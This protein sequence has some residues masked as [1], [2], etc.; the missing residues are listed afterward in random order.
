MFKKHGW[1]VIGIFVMI[2]GI[3]ALTAILQQYTVNKTD[4][5][6]AAA[7]TTVQNTIT[8]NAVITP[9]QIYGQ[10]CAGQN[11]G[12]PVVTVYLP[13]SAGSL[14][15]PTTLVQVKST[16]GTASCVRS[17]PFQFTIPVAADPAMVKALL[18]GN[19]HV[20]QVIANGAVGSAFLN[21]K[22]GQTINF[23]VNLAAPK[24]T[25]VNKINS[26]K[27]S[28]TP[29]TTVSRY[30]KTYNV[31]LGGRLI[32]STT[33]LTYTD[34]SA[35][36]P[37]T[38]NTYTV[39]PAF[40]SSVPLNTI[41]T[42]LCQPASCRSSI[43]ISVPKAFTPG[44]PSLPS[45]PIG[46]VDI[47]NSTQISGW[48]CDPADY[49]KS[50]TVHIYDGNPYGVAATSA[51]R[52]AVV[53]ADL[54]R[55]DLVTAIPKVCASTPL[56]GFTLN[57]QGNPTVMALIGDGRPH[58]IYAFGVNIA[59][60]NNTELIGD[61]KSVT[62]TPATNP[63]STP[64]TSKLN[65]DG[66]YTMTWSAV[67]GAVKYAV[68]V[69]GY[70]ITTTSGTSYT[71]DAGVMMPDSSF[72]YTFVPIFNSST[73]PPSQIDPTTN[74]PISEATSKGIL[75]AVIDSVYNVVRNTILAA[76]I[77]TPPTTQTVSPG[78]T[79]VTPPPTPLP[80][81]GNLS[82]LAIVV[83]MEPNTN[84]AGAI[85]FGDDV[86]NVQKKLFTNSDST[87]Q[88]YKE[89]SYGNL[90]I[91]PVA[92]SSTSGG[93]G[94]VAVKIPFMKGFT[95]FPNDI[96]PTYPNLSLGYKIAFYLANA[97][98]K[99]FG[100]KLSNYDL[101]IYVWPI[102]P[103]WNIGVAMDG[104]GDP[105]S[106]VIKGSRIWI[107]TNQDS[108]VYSHEIG[109]VL[110]LYH[111]TGL[112]SNI[113]CMVAMNTCN[114]T[115]YG[116][117]NN[118]MGN[119]SSK[120]QMDI[121][122]KM[123]LNWNPGDQNISQS[124]RYT[125]IGRE[126]AEAKATHLQIEDT[127]DEF[128]ID[129]VTDYGTFGGNS[130]GVNFFLIRPNTDGNLGPSGTTLSMN[131]LQA[132]MYDGTS[133]DTYL[134][135]PD[136]KFAHNFHIIQI[137][138]GAKSADVYVRFDVAPT[139]TATTETTAP[140]EGKID[141]SWTAISPAPT[142]G[143]EIFRDGTSITT[144]SAT[145]TTYV[146]TGLTPGSSHTYKIRGFDSFTELPGKTYPMMFSNTANA[147][148]GASLTL[149]TPNVYA[150]IS[151]TC[152]G[153]VDVSWGAITNAV[154]YEVYRDNETT[155]F[156]TITGTSIT[157]SGFVP[158]SS[159]TIKVRA[160]NGTVYSA[161]GSATATA[162]AACSVN[163]NTPVLS[164]SVGSTCTTTVLTWTNVGANSYV[165]YDGVTNQQIGNSQAATTVT[166]T[167]VVGQTSTYYVVAYIGTSASA[168]SNTV[169]FTPSCSTPPPAL[170]DCVTPQVN[171]ASGHGMTWFGGGF[172]AIQPGNY[173][174]V[175][176]N[177]GMMFNPTGGWQI[178]HQETNGVVSM[179]MINDRAVN[180]LPGPGSY[181]SF[182]SQ[183]ALEASMG[184]ATTPVFS[185][186]YGPIGMYLWDT[187][188][189]ADNVNGNPNPTF[190][191]VKMP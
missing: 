76:V 33:N 31:Y 187:N 47:L 173:M 98:A 6:T 105:T 148:A 161:F 124:G 170:T 29:A 74:Q 41:D 113:N 3:I 147:T 4:N 164:V 182:P 8:G 42:K 37:G 78:L 43:S 133:Y 27:L 81:S 24:L 34:L 123:V 56:H 45:K 18:D 174:V 154:S 120:K 157:L 16:K 59:N 159:H 150:F 23:G 130:V 77:S 165:L 69:E 58:S 82:V 160:K 13:S 178:R 143:Y 11:V 110:G 79:I 128:F 108:D 139:L 155:P 162:S 66:S 90:K 38:I 119:S 112:D 126:Y 129:Y 35:F 144:V 115:P 171:D 75:A 48:T 9:I 125:V 26:I 86:L 71:E 7:L 145:T 175:Y 14:K 134:A 149:D 61:G 40:D 67:P 63:N 32:T 158:S 44:S 103:V 92:T 70:L 12:L 188:G 21:T 146:D 191:L 163:V 5:I 96:A 109:H 88:F 53:N 107:N 57:L 19:S 54:S 185:H 111:G 50:T 65:A 156:T 152:E 85:A 95:H 180:Y 136:G 168:H 140:V 118:I 137:K 52:I 121:Y 51:K 167:T 127:G 179:Y 135:P 22:S 104:I 94:A 138:H 122:D 116:D 73:V 10:G 46:Y 25:T 2:V 100:Y 72:A 102:T 89:A 153:K 55:P 62:L 1:A 114:T 36:V 169:S 101:V 99:Q 64:A 106:A 177:G 151:P 30:V 141:L 60:T 39:L 17:N 87:A 186:D 166:K 190:C 97:R 20:V 131:G 93:S 15:T 117:K 80:K 28:W 84:G 132:L 172:V 184:G 49:T 181:A 176:K 189:Y 68:Y 183:S 142:G 91:N 83:G